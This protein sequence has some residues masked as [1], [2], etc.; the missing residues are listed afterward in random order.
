MRI[1][2]IHAD[3]FGISDEIT[4]NILDTINNGITNSISIVTNTDSFAGS[5]EKL[6]KLN[7][8]RLSLHI[9][10]VDGT[11]ISA[12]SEVNDIVN[13]DGEFKFSFLSLW[14]KYITSSRKKKERLKTQIKTEIVLQI[15]RYQEHLSAE[16]P[17]RIDSH[18]HFHMI[19]FIFDIIL[20]I[21]VDYPINFI[22]IPYELR[23][24]HASINKNYLSANI[25]KNLLLNRIAI[26]KSPLLKEYNIE[27]NEYFIGVLS[28]GNC[29]YKNL[30]YGLK[31]I[32]KKGNPKSVDILFHPGGVK[33]SKSVTWTT[34][35]MF[36]SYYS[37]ANR[38]REAKVLKDIKTK[39]TVLDYE[40]IF[41][42]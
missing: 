7:H 16:N 25:I 31:E 34:R 8:V 29:T 26:V 37:S 33:D 13:K 41:N 1:I 40:T 11:P 36:H 18:M 30:K 3:D 5:I 17:L 21:S 9:N 14:L 24:Y 2:N 23:Y 10:L 22:R 20:E 4:D 32:S 28:T 38:E 6:K 15:K 35:K 39:E 12:K 27:R 19:P 42:N